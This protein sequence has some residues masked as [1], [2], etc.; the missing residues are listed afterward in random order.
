MHHDTIAALATPAGSG[1][2]GIIRLSGPTALPIAQ[3]LFSQSITVPRH[4]YIGHIKSIYHG[5][6]IYFKGPDSFTGEDVIE[7]HIHSGQTII[8]TL[9]TKL[10]EHGV[11][12]ANP[13]E[14]TY[15]AVLNQKIDLTQAEGIIDIIDATSQQSHHVALAHLNGSLYTWIST[16]K[17][18]LIRQLEF[19]EGSIDFPDEVPHLD[20]NHA[21]NELIAIQ[22]Q[23]NETLSLQDFGE[24]IKQGVTC[25]IIGK[26]NSGKSS[27]LNQLL[28]KNRAIVTATPGTTRDYLSASIELGGLNYEFIDSAGYRQTNQAIEKK[29]IRQLK[30]LMN[31]S[32]AI[33][34]IVDQSKAP[35]DD[36][37]KLSILLK[38]Q[39]KPIWLIINKN[40]LKTCRYK[41]LLGLPELSISTKTGNGISQLKSMLINHFSTDPNKHN[42]GLICNARQKACIHQLNSHISHLLATIRSSIEDDLL[43]VDLKAAI[44]T[45]GELT[46]E[47][48]TETVL[49]GIFSRFCVGK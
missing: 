41:N 33:L 45:C 16:I 37:K 32:S 7:F 38:K 22:S 4:V 47:S 44:Q 39:S 10:Y 43:A 8:K 25:V 42:L 26:P 20:R 11:R 13:G 31:Q 18:Q 14:F 17:N 40:D 30:P 48:V 3:S 23:L 19:V 15:R 12:P 6:V 5:C 29:G 46:G 24:H 2:I 34:W 36:D 21:I 28:G 35:T 1:G 27:L 9:L 49:D